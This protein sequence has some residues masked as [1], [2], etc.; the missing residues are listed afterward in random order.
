VTLGRG[1][2]SVVVLVLLARRE[3]HGSLEK[4]QMNPR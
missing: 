3:P 4:C 1:M 2:S